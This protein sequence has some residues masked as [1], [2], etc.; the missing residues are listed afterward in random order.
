MTSKPKDPA[1]NLTLELRRG[2]IV[3][4]IL[5]LLEEERYGYALREELSS[6]GLEVPEGTLY[7][8]LRRL[9]SQGLLKSR[10]QTG[11]SRPRR[12]YRTSPRGREALDTMSQEWRSLVG[13]LERLLPE[14]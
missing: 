10:W 4:A 5:A 12:Y 3:L 7:P 1:E 11:E 9:E 8:L 13:V 2:L 6:Q 14:R